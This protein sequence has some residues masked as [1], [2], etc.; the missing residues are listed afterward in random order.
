MTG[1]F[2]STTVKFQLWSRATRRWNNGESIG[3]ELGPKA[4][5]PSECIGKAPIKLRRLEEIRLAE[6]KVS[7]GKEKERKKESKGKRKRERKAD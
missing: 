6:A 5:A 3:G 4:S 1:A 2:R 7:Q